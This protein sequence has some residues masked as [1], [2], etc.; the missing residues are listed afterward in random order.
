MLL[1]G[2][3]IFTTWLPR[4]FNQ[5]PDHNAIVK[6]RPSSFYILPPLIYRHILSDV[7]GCLQIV[8]QNKS[9]TSQ[10]HYIGSFAV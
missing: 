2:D 8:L 5:Q 4:E 1:S 7:M 6:A 9:I 3:E 10:V